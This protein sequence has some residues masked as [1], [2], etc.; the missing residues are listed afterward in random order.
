M[1]NCRKFLFNW[2]SKWKSNQISKDWITKAS[3]VIHKII[4]NLSE[5][6]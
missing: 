2:K 3:I 5:L 6:K 4:K 1:R